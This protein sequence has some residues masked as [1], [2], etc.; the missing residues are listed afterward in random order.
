MTAVSLT[1]QE[2]QDRKVTGA[3]LQ[4]MITELAAIYGWAW[5]HIRPAQT[6]HGWRTPI[7][8]PLGKGWPDLVLVNPIRRRTLAVEIKR[9]V[10]DA[11]TAD[12]RYVHLVLEQAGW[13]VR[14]WRPSDLT[15]GEIQ[16]ELQR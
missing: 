2:R 5:L 16:R 10:D 12:Q 13:A 11:L 1:D 15:S 8:G 4:G 14:V 7:E 6:T 3:A 9:Q